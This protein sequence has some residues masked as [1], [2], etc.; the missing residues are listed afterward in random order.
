MIARMA[1]TVLAICQAAEPG[2]AERALLRVARHLPAH[3][4]ELVLTAPA[5]GAL[6]EEARAAGLPVHHLAVGGFERG[7]WPRA[8]MSWPRARALARRLAPDLVYLNGAV[9]QRLAP[10]LLNRTLVLHLRDFPESRP[11]LW[12]SRRFWD[13]VPVVLCDSRAVAERATAL[14]APAERLRAVYAPVEPV[15]PAERPE[16]SDGGPVVGYVGRI[17]PRKGTLDLLR[18]APLV[19]ERRP[20]ARIVI[21]GED[22]YGADPEYRAEVER[23]AHD[24][25]ARVLLLGR[26]PD[27]NRLMSW[28]DVLAVPSVSE[29]FGTVAAEAL[30]A[31]TPVAATASGGMS[32]YVVPG[33]NGAIVPPSNPSALAEALV[34]LL[35]RGP[36]L[37][38]AARAAAAPFASERVAAAVARQLSV[39]L[40][41]G[42]RRGS[43]QA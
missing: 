14:G 12:R 35:E 8:V 28:F 36:D 37:R 38:D 31:G 29:P 24:L 27:A 13:A 22:D 42:R 9:T 34:S 18:A 25:G 3:G 40:A 23:A 33:R 17:E 2:G 30:V 20:D 7:R 39:A 10:A 16:W 4:F 6:E 19:F 1:A 11:R 26:V 5:R 43:R 21:V 41:A 15:A 32:E